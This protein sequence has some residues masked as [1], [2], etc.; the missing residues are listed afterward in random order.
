MGARKKEENPNEKRRVGA[1]KEKTG[2]SE[3]IGSETRERVRKE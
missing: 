1:R 2:R 3:E